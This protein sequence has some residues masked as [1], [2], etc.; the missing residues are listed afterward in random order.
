[1]D[2]NWFKVSRGWD[3][4]VGPSDI[5]GVLCLG[6]FCKSTYV[7]STL[8]KNTFARSTTKNFKLKIKMFPANAFRS[9]PPLKKKKKKPLTGSC[10]THK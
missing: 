2:S 5:G 4:F 9:T 8:R 1:M 3:L 10:I 7:P 6:P